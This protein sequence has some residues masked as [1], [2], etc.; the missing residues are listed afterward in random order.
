MFHCSI[1]ESEPGRGLAPALAILS[2]D[3]HYSVRYTETNT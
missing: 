2:L 3:A 1:A